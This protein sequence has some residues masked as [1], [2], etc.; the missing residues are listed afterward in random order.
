MSLILGKVRTFRD[1]RAGDR[2]AATL[3]SSNYSHIHLSVQQSPARGDHSL[4]PQLLPAPGCPG[5]P[6]SRWSPRSPSCG[7]P[8]SIG[9]RGPGCP[10]GASCVACEALASDES[11]TSV[12]EG[13]GSPVPVPQV[14]RPSPAPSTAAR[15]P[16]SAS[17]P[18]KVLGTAALPPPRGPH[19]GT[20]QVSAAESQQDTAR[21]QNWLLHQAEDSHRQKS[22]FPELQ[23]RLQ[24]HRSHLSPRHT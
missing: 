14:L 7:G 19:L 13:S 8:R 2:G 1:P 11:Q 21:A 6:P 24:G 5:L 22:W 18:Q 15:P 4:T 9:A 17:R 23:G 12:G 16:P 10:P 20:G 3:R